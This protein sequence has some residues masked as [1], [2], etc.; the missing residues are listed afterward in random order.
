MDVKPGSGR[1]RAIFRLAVSGQRHQKNVRAA[2]R[3][4]AAGH[5]VAVEARQADVDQRDL[6]MRGNGAL[7]TLLSIHGGV[8][9]MSLRLEQLLKRFAV[10]VAVL[11]DQDVARRQR[12]CVIPTRS[13]RVSTPSSATRRRT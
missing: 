6:R 1:P 13:S 12:R 9:A 11:D 3:A 7:H 10:V 2:G 4:N 8:D 5:F